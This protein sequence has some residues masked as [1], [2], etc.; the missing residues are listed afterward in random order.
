MSSFDWLSKLS[1]RVKIQLV[2]PTKLSFDWLRQKRCATVFTF[3]G[4]HARFVNKK[5]GSFKLKEC[6]LFAHSL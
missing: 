3:E 1:L 4:R 2:K 5:R 6:G